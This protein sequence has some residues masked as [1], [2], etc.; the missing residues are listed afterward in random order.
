MKTQYFQ[1]KDEA[2]WLEKRNQY[3]TSTEVSALFGLNQWMTAFELY[4]IKRGLIDGTL[5]D[6]NFLKFG[7]ILETPICEMILLEKPQWK[8]SPM[9][10]FA[11]DDVDRMGAS[12]D[13]VVTLENGKIGLL[14]IKSISYKEY[15]EK[16]IEHDENDIEAPTNYEVQMQSQLE[17]IQRYDFCVMAVFILDTR[18]LKFI[19]R[20]RDIELGAKLRQAVKEFW[21]MTEPPQPDYA[22]DKSILSKVAPDCDPNNTLDATENNRI[23]ELAAMYKAEKDLEKQCKENA[24]KFYAELIHALGNARYAW[25]NSHKITVSDIKPNEGKQVTED[26]VGTYIGARDGYKRLTITEIKK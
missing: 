1:I 8:I 10:V 17:V 6:N 7:R 16:F 12:F 18:Q 14:E 26:M 21:A 11:Y 3:V 25:T 19:I 15:K 22:R 23:T 9:R 13:R 5:E 20:E 2:A 24:D 4:H